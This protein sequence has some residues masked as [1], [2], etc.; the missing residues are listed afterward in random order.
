MTYLRVNAPNVNSG[1]RVL[2]AVPNAPNVDVY[3]NG[4]LLVSNLSF[5][6]ISTYLSLT[7]GTYELQIY[8]SGFYDT[9]LAT[10]NVQ[11]APS[12]NYTI[13]VVTLG[14][15]F[16]FK[17]RDAPIAVSPNSSYLRFM[18]L[19]QTAPLLN[20]NLPNG[21]Q[22]FN[23]VE[24]LETTGYYTTSPGIYNFVV[25][26]SGGTA[27]NKNLKDLTLEGGKLYT[28]Y[29]IGVF[30]GKPPLGYLFVEDER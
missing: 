15:L 17:L 1:F 27:V 14:G 19:S 21:T 8:R 12:A 18:N 16:L 20:L 3:A 2:H 11:L 24:Y 7:P 4:S 26:F 5:S 10:Q 9:P 6:S 25:E 22:L 29:V 13:S 30:D 23:S 28:I